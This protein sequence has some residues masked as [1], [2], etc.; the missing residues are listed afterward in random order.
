MKAK[1]EE[2]ISSLR[3]EYENGQKML[4]E[5]DAKRKSVSDTLLRIEG[6]MAILKELA[7]EEEKVSIANGASDAPNVL[8]GGAAAPS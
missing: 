7:D 8:R 5:I 4:A 2:R 3:S 6:A 1:L